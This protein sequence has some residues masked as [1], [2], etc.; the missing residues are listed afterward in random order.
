MLFP[1]LRPFP[2]APSAP[3]P[4]PTAMGEVWD[5]SAVGLAAGAF[6]AQREA[7]GFPEAE[8]TALP[9]Q[10]AAIVG[11]M[12]GLGLEEDVALEGF[13]GLWSTQ[14]SWSILTWRS[15]PVQ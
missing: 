4:C 15:A 12:E 7:R 10:G 11:V 6:P 2:K 14:T 5:G 1:P 3:S 8:G 9:G 13:K